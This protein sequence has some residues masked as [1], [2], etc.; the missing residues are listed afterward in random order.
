MAEVV[1]RLLVATPTTAARGRVIAS[2]FQFYLDGNDNLRLEGWSTAD[3]TTLQVYGRFV[4]EDGGI[5]VFQMSLFV[6]STA[7]RFVRDFA[8]ARGYLLN[9]VAIVTGATPVIGQVFTRISIIRGFSGATLVMGTLLQGYVTSQQALAWP[10]SALQQTDEIPGYVVQNFAV[11]PGVGNPLLFA[12]PT[13]RHWSLL[14]ATCS[15]TTDATAISRRTYLST[16]SANQ[17][18]YAHTIQTCPASTT[19]SFCWANGLT[20]NVESSGIPNTTALPSRTELDDGES[21]VISATNLQAGDE[22]LG[23]GNVAVLERLLVN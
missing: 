6:S 20:G 15:L 12:V 10:G 13:G 3:D 5:E 8:I 19:R 4:N 22:F 16:L 23:G 21:I 7:T 17:E 11:S 2:P 1:E 14:S 18:F 9:V